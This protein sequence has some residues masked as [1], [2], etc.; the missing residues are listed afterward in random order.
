MTS[1]RI[2]GSGLAVALYTHFFLTLLMVVKRSSI[3]FSRE[4]ETDGATELR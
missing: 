1:P 2:Y 3:A 4:Y